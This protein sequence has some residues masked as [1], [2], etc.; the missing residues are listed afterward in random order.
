MSL[1]EITPV[2]AADRPPELPLVV[3]LDGAVLRSAAIQHTVFGAF[4]HGPAYLWR[5]PGFLL[6]GVEALKRVLIKQ[7]VLDSETWPVRADVIEY[8]ESEAARHRRIILVTQADRIVAD[9][10]L[11]VHET[12]IDGQLI[13]T[14]KRA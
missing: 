9:A 14:G 4:R 11:E 8:L 13:A 12:W 5:N 1:N 10:M 7:A 6:S 3:D 2:T